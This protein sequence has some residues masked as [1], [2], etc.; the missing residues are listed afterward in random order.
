MKLCSQ[1]RKTP[2]PFLF[3]LLLAGFAAFLTW[4]TLLTSQFDAT[5]RLLMTGAVFLATAGTLSHYM[6][7][8][9]RRHCRHHDLHKTARG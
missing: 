2:W 8:C 7:S 6:V 4:L 3:A 9:M 1:C 5:D